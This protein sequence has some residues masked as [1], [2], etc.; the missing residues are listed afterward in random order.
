MAEPVRKLCVARSG[1]HCACGA[2]RVHPLRTGPDLVSGRFD[3]C[4]NG[5]E[6][7][8]HSLRRRLL[9][10][11]QHVERALDIGDVP[12]HANAKIHID[13]VSW[14]NLAAG[15]TIVGARGIGSGEHRRTC[16]AVPGKTE[17]T[18]LHLCLDECRDARLGCTGPDLP[19]DQIEDLECMTDRLFHAG[20][21]NA[22]LA[23]AQGSDDRFGT[24][25]LRRASCGVERLDE[26][27]VHAMREAVTDL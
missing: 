2:V 6:T 1:Q 18:A 21:L 12:I 9:S 19:C 24:G 14:C 25:D 22:G 16:A 5:G 13:D 26:V 7:M 15:G 10:V 4:T 27:K 23:L 3:G 17:S 11:T 8:L 20:E